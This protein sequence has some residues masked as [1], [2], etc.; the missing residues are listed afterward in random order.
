L[1]KYYYEF[2][3]GKLLPAGPLYNI[4]KDKLLVLRKFLEKNL[5]KGFIRASLS[6][7][8]SP[9]LFAKKPNRGFC[10]Y[11]DYRAFNTITI[12]NRYP[13]LLIQEIL[14]CFSKTKF[15]TKLDIIATFNYIRITKKQ[16]YFIVFNTYYSFFEILVI[17]FGLFNILVIFQAR[18][19]KILYL[20]L[21]VF[22]TIYIND[23]LVYLD[24]LLEYKE[25]I[26]KYK[27]EVIEI[28]YLGL[29]FS[30]KNIWIN[31]AKIKYIID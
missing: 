29:I 28:T 10:F 14:V 6:P 18:I 16:E 30:I 2:L 27:F 8:V 7:V 9:V 3:L 12:K 19:N 20:Y 11:V 21:D 31:P 26:K 1:P 15:Y 13:L 17:L 4:L 5:S 24:N 25:Y 22:C 23:I